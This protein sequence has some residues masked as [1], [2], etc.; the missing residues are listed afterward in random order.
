[1][2]KMA[3]YSE[4]HK[5]GFNDITQFEGMLDIKIVV[6]HWSCTDVFEK[7]MSNDAPHHKTVF[8][9]LHNGRYFMIKKLKAFI[10]TPYVCD[11]SYQGFTSHRDN[12]CKYVCDICNGPDYYKYPSKQGNAA[13]VCGTANLTI[14]MTCIS[15]CH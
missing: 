3:G 14:V 13:I 12:H 7:Y 1:M 4:Q 10:G 9:Y 8:F 15:S 11:Y 6:F 2:Q 5:I